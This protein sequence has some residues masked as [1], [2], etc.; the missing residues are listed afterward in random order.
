[1]LTY[2]YMYMYTFIYI[3]NYYIH[4][5]VPG[6]SLLPQDIVVTYFHASVIPCEPA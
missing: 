6:L 5:S 4:E 1:M 2:L 3:L